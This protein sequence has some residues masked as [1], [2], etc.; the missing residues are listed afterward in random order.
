MIPQLGEPRRFRSSGGEISYHDLGEGPPVLFLHGFPTNARLWRREAWLCAQRMRVIVPD[1]LGYGASDRP[2]DADLSEPAQAGYLKELIGALGLEQL[3]IMG[4][5]IGGAIA[6]LLALEP[7]VDVA[8][9]VLLD[10]ACFDAW[11]IEGMRHLQASTP[12]QETPEFADQVVRLVLDLGIAHPERLEAGTVEGYL[13][14]WL[15]DPH[16]LFRAARAVTGRGLAGRDRELAA[17]ELPA[18]VVW[19]EDDPFLPA[20]LAERLGEVFDGAAVALLP[21]CSHFV[22]EDAPQTVPQLV[23]QYLRVRL[24]GDGHAH[25]AAEAGPVPIYL[26][27]PPEGFPEDLAFEP[28]AEEAGEED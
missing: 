16:S 11:P 1:L 10:A 22:T 15:Q 26:E 7:E 23:F 18:F 21:G 12:E 20:E 9:L 28:S 17:L 14:P 3:A 5:D 6:Q 13:E 4:H 8:A 24:V 19:G 27:R 25:E 2:V